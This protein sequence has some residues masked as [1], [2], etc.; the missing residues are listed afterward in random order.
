MVGPGLFLVVVLSLSALPGVALADAGSP[1]TAA[2][3]AQGEDTYTGFIDLPA[4]GSSFGARAEIPVRGWAVDT[5]ADGWSG[6]DDIQVYLGTREQGGALVAHPTIGLGRPDVAAAL[7]NPYFASSGFSGT[8]S[9]ASIPAGDQVLSIYIHTPAKGWW[10]KQVN[11]A[12]QGAPSLAFSDD[13]I[14]V[15]DQPDRLNSFGANTDSQILSGYA[16]DRNATAD[17]VGASGSGVARVQVY[18]DG[19]RGDGKYL[20]DVAFGQN[21][22]AAQSYG[23]RF[24]KAGWQVTIHPNEMDA[25]HHALFFYAQSAV[26][27]N[28]TLVIVPFTTR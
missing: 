20:G 26:S 24:K 5:T 11:V 15:V 3:D 14:L 16:L 19:P 1:W 6:I 12:I 8:V 13:P 22:P 23:D 21:E 25:A 18:L 27:G 9:A 10:Y 17:N 7:N 28:E 4:P 2:P